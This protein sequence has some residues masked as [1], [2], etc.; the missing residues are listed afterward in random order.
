MEF[1]W[2]WCNLFTVYII[3]KIYMIYQ[4]KNM[5]MQQTEYK[6]DPHYIFAI[7]SDYSYP[8]SKASIFNNLYFSHI[9]TYTKMVGSTSTKWK[10]TMKNG[11]KTAVNKLLT[12]KN[13]NSSTQKM[14]R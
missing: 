7:D 6:D 8:L 11:K 5:S 14:Q 13:W 2:L 10:K 9:N 3:P 1:I 4:L 12:D